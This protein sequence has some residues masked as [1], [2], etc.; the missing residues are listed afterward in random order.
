MPELYLHGL[1][2]RDFDLALRGL[3]GDAAPLS[4]SS[5]ARLKTAWD[6]E[7]E[8][9]R[10]ESLADLE[11]VDVWVDG[12]YVKAGLEQEKA[13]MLVVIAALGNGE[14]RV[15]AVE[16]GARANRPRVGRRSYATSSGAG[17]AVRRVPLKYGWSVATA[18]FAGR[19]TGCA[20]L[21][22]WRA[23]TSASRKLTLGS[24]TSTLDCSSSDGWKSVGPRSKI[25]KADSPGRLC[26]PCPRT[27][28]SPI[29]PT[30]QTVG[31]RAAKAP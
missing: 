15:L 12:I 19:N 2:E 3:L 11:P 8:A 25:T 5:I 10:S 27:H 21:T 16:S 7:Y 20:S 28:P 23:S 24:G 14:K 29:S 9:W 18:A 30:A 4:A 13:A 22:P 1:A 17:C 6:A 26:H 31:S